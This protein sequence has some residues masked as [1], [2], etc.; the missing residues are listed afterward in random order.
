MIGGNN[1]AFTMLGVE[2]N[3][4]T[5]DIRYLILDPH[6]TGSDDIKSITGKISQMIGY[7][8]KACGWRDKSLFLPNVFYSLCLP[9]RPELC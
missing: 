6:Y 8:A 2:F 5:R 3:E 4:E 7:K 1:L 9:Q